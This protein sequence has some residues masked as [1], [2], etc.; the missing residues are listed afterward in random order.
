MDLHYY[1]QYILIEKS[2]SI[3]RDA[4]S[5]ILGIS[6][7]RKSSGFVVGLRPRIETYYIGKK[8]KLKVVGSRFKREEI[9]G[10]PTR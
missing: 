7:L 6:T 1:L 4:N 5:N 8:S 9:L 3:M 2:R 10:I